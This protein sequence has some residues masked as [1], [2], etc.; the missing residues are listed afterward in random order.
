MGVDPDGPGW[1]RT[2]GLRFVDGGL[3]VTLDWPARDGLPG[4]GLTRTRDDLDALLADR[5]VAVGADLR[6]ATTVTGPLLDPDGRLAGVTARA[7]R[8]T[9]EFRAPVVV[10]ASGAA[11]R[12]P[13]ALNL[14]RHPKRPVG[15]AVRRYFRAPPGF[16]DRHLDI[17]LGLRHLGSEGSP[18]PG[19]AWIF[20]LGDGRVNV[21]LAVHRADG[22]L[23][24]IDHRDLMARWLRSTPPEWE[25]AEERNADGPV[26]GAALPMGL[27]R[28]PQ[29]HR[30]VLLVGDCAGT[31]NPFTGEGIGYA[32]ESGE[33]AACVVAGALDHPAGREREHALG[34]YATQLQARF[35]RYYRLGRGFVNVVD[36]PRALDLGLRH[37]LPR[38][39]AMTAL[40]G[41]VTGP[42]LTT[43]QHTT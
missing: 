4:Y 5:A 40:L 34:G 43:Q 28:V 6:T 42:R 9:V 12:L 16:D 36:H 7:G 35:G 39:R 37:V 27:N 8:N 20:G 33:L 11:A 30:G 3:A 26:L 18:L 32:M 22:R 1:S 21:G 25:L 19:Y 14:H 29:Y 24:G 2:A 10:A 23:A 13:T 31:V 15:V 17:V 41:L 38:R